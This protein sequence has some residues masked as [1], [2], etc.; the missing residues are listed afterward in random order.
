MRIAGLRPRG[1]E[2]ALP[3]ARCLLLAWLAAWPGVPVLAQAVSIVG[4]QQAVFIN[5]VGGLPARWETCAGPCA[6]PDAPRQFLLRAGEGGNRLEWVVPGDAEATAAL[7]ELRYTHEVRQGEGTTT[8]IVSSVAPWDGIQLIHR[9]R[10]RRDSPVLEASLQIPA[11]ARLR[12]A[13]GTDLIPPPLPGLGALY[14][15]ASA[16]AITADGAARLDTGVDGEPVTALLDPGSWAG[17]RGRFWALLAAATEPVA[18]TAAEPQAN[19][20]RLD[21]GRESGTAGPV[22]FRL[23]AGPIE[24]TALAAADPV[25]TGMLYAGLWQPLRWLAFGLQA[26]LEFWQA[27]VGS[28]ALAIILLSASARLLMWPL[29]FIAGRWQDQ[30]NRSQSLLAAE[31][32]GTKAAP[33]GAETE[34]QALAVNVRHGVSPWYTLKSHAGLLVQIP[35]F[36]AAFGMLGEQFGLAGARFLWVADLSLPDR[37]LPFAAPAPFF[38]THLNLLP[39]LMAGLTVLAAR[40]QEEP[41]LPPALRL[42]QRRRRYAMAAAFFVLLYTLPAGMVLYWTTNN[43]LHLGGVLARRLKAAGRSA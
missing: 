1:Y 15:R 7:G 42:G 29:T 9:Y 20:P 11:G 36:L 3:G 32:A 34:G 12:L 21:A 39:F 24:R 22:E 19:Q 14:S 16:V 5:L 26:I 10:L 23:Y 33:R 28:W 6:G 43:A 40:L 37:L 41:G 18:V 2:S 25:L 38:G 35:V 13:A 17:L 30:V 4:E 8:V 27:R 31:L